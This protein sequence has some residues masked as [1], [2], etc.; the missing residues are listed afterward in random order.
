MNHFNLTDVVPRSGK[1]IVFADGTYMLQRQ[2][3]GS[4][5]NCT[6]GHG[7]LEVH[8][9]SSFATGELFYQSGSLAPQHSARNH[10]SYYSYGTSAEHILPVALQENALEWFE[11]RSGQRPAGIR[12]QALAY[13][14]S[15]SN[16]NTGADDILLMRYRYDSADQ[17]LYD[18]EG[19]EPIAEFV[20]DGGKTLVMD[21]VRINTLALDADT[22]AAFEKALHSGFHPCD[23]N[24]GADHCMRRLAWLASEYFLAANE[25]K[26]TT[27]Y[28]LKRDVERPAELTD[29]IVR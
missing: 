14:Y 9:D 25:G 18:I 16:G 21:T 17:A 3:F 19:D 8:I 1:G 13:M 11:Q 27:T 4:T 7:H 22:E 29:M 6:F 10:Y 24:L 23:T 12:Q 28:V 20:S 2:G 5:L 15:S 26:Q